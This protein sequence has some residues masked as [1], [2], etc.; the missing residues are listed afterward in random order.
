MLSD[1]TIDV[2]LLSTDLEVTKNFYG[3]KIV[4]RNSSSSRRT[5]SSPS[6]ARETV[7]WW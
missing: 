6:S 7:G 4:P 5:S 2:M 1:H 3:D